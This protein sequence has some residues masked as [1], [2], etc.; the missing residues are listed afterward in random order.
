MMSRVL[1]VA[2]LTL[3]VGPAGLVAAT[4]LAFEDYDYVRRRAGACVV[5]VVLAVLIAW[6]LTRA[7]KVISP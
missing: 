3:V 4:V 7:V 2:L 5:V 1:D 6:T